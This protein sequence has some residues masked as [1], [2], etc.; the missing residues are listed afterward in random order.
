MLMFS[1]ND[2]LV[3]L[4]C[5]ESRDEEDCGEEGFEAEAS[6]ELLDDCAGRTGIS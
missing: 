3:A 4:L 2:V 6:D 5:S 1:S